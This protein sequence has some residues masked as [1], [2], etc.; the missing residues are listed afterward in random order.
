MTKFAHLHLHT[1]FSLL[2]GA[3]RMEPLMN[4]LKELGQDSVAITDHG[5]MYGAIDFYLA[6]KKAGIKPI[7]GCE[8]Y[9]AART[10]FDKE[11]QFDSERNHLVLL[12]ENEKGYGNLIKIVSKAWTEGFYTKPRVDKELLEKY[13][14]GL[15]CLSACLAGEIPQALLNNDY[16]KA[17]ETALWY[18]N[19]FGEGNY[20]LEIQNHG[21]AEQIKILGDIIKL[22]RETG[23][24]L[25]ATND[26]HYLEKEDAYIQKILIC[27]Q[28]KHT[29][30]EDTGME[31]STSEF[32]VKSGG[33]MLELFP[34]TPEAID[35]TVKIAERCNFDFSFGHTLLP[36]YETPEGLTNIEYFNDLC[37]KGLAKRY[38]ENCDPFYKQRLEYELSVINSMGFTDYFLIVWDFINYAKSKGI[39]VGPGRGSGAG[40][41]AAYC[42]EI[43]AIDPI[44]Y[45]L[46]FERFLNPERISMPDFDIDFCQERRGEVIEYVK[47]KYGE[48]HVSQIVT[49]G[50]MAAKGAVRDVG[51]VLGMPY[52]ACDSVAKEIPGELGITI[53]KALDTSKDFKAMYDGSEEIK[54]LVDISLK[55]EGMS[56]N[57][58]MHAAG[59]VI[60]PESV[61][62]YAPLAKSGESV[63]TQYNM[64]HVDKIGLLKMDF[65]GLRTLTVIEDAVKMIKKAEPDFDIYNID[66]DDPAVYKM[67][68]NGDTYG[69]F[70]CES[71]GIRALMINMKPKNLED[72]I[73][74]IALYRP[75]PMDFIPKYLENRN[76]P[77]RITYASPKMKDI[78]EVTYGCIVYQEQVMQIFRDLA[79]YS[80]GR[81]DLIR[82]AISKKDAKVLAD[83]RNSFIHGSKKEDG[84]VEC[85]GCVANG[86]TEKDAARIFE[87]MASFASYAFNKS[88]SAAY[89]LVSF[90]TAYLRCHY[91]KEFMAAML[92]SVLDN[93]DKVVVYISECNRIGIDVL[94]PDVNESLHSFTVVGGKILFGLQAI[95]NLGRGLI[96]A[97][98]DE[99][100]KAG[101]Y[102][103]FASFCKRI[104]G[105][106]FN[107]RGIEGLIKS[108]ALDCFGFNRRQMLIMLPDIIDGIDSDKKRN[109]EGQLGFFSFQTENSPGAEPTP[110]NVPEMPKKEL[111]ANEKAATGLYMTGHPMNEY[112]EASAQVNSVKTIDLTNDEQRREK[113]YNNNDRIRLLAFIDTVRKKITKENRTIAFVT[114]EDTYG[115]VEVIVFSQKFEE[116]QTKLREDAVALIS[117]RLSVKDDEAS[118]I[119]LEEITLCPSPDFFDRPQA[120]PREFE[121]AAV[122]DKNVA[123][124]ANT[125]NINERKAAA[126]NNK[127]LFLRFPSKE[128]VKAEKAGEILLYYNYGDTP[129]KFYYTDT[130]EYNMETGITVDVNKKLLDSLGR[131]L[132]EKN[133]VLKT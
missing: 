15:I 4:K 50:T 125:A 121:I 70:Q 74:V 77:D 37:N 10:R 20:Y 103:T 51:R 64:K 46:L 122:N 97:I 88:H 68:G 16:E 11:H 9:V 2:D 118:K 56:R 57:I 79:G 38:G 43:T 114:A 115:S 14:E 86:L 128:S 100:E 35:N 22:S 96:N 31:F 126:T 44:K 8:V 92:T 90:Q 104:H 55:I 33:E 124:A 26:S 52:G 94:P 119:I 98:I 42:L 111:L 75:G 131:L 30:D 25:V 66:I 72:I 95:K 58:G 65:L 34:D 63:V 23:I 48:D 6:A 130:K 45:N 71:G 87:D 78:L 84:S 54:K 60:T 82:R 49:F 17:R 7:I 47:N 110:P 99:R 53:Q 67:L 112:K 83:E 101:P 21:L 133:V 5:V 102:K 81:S 93:T 69:V 59:V 105:G 108:G 62:E 89:A 18:K 129:V 13:H 91:P 41:I 29:V 76:R 132:E 32:Y 113:G 107:R 61:D 28:T 106:D 80:L 1:E 116:Y 36:K 109:I 39:P 40:S 117:G 120:P 123:D 73:A 12:C 85:A 127:G 24:P 3:L 19:V 27:I